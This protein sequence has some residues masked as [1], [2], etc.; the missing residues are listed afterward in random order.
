[1]TI[2]EKELVAKCRLGTVVKKTILIAYFD[3]ESCMEC[4]K[5]EM[6]IKFKKL[7]WTALKTVL[8]TN[9]PD[10]ILKA[11][12]SCVNVPDRLPTE[13]DYRTNIT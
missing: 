11:T 1:M 3:K 7:K 6:F 12:V 13:N 8:D 5:S 10:P 9:I 2:N 4:D